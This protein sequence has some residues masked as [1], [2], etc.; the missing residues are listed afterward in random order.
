MDENQKL[1][2]DTMT[3]IIRDDS[4]LIFCQ[5]APSYRSV[6]IK[7]TPVQREALMLKSNGVS[8]GSRVWEEISRVIIESPRD[9]DEPLPDLLRATRLKTALSL[10]EIYEQCGV[11]PSRLSEIENGMDVPTPEEEKK[12]REWIGGGNAE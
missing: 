9:Q 10:R 6:R 2:P 4:P 8:G 12:I 1:P 5:D 7:L 3:V 11:T